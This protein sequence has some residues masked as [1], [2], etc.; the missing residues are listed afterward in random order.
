MAAVPFG[1]SIRTIIFIGFGTMSLLVGGLGAYGI[2]S[3]DRAGSVVA[4]TY[5]YPLMAINF[6]RAASLDFTRMSSELLL[7]IHGVPG[8]PD[9]QTTIDQLEA[10]LFAQ[11]QVTEQR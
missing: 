6:A 4:D 9:S 5:D 1:K 10:T 11:L 2:Y 7:A 8:R 3:T